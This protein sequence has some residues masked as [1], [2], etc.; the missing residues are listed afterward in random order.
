M[1]MLYALGQH[2]A[3]VSFQS[4]LQPGEKVFAFLDDVYFTCKPERVRTL[5]NSLSAFLWEH[6]FIRIN[7]GKTKI[8]NRAGILPRNCQDIIGDNGL[9]A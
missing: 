5:Y 9:S 4:H 3:L 8:W 1:P 7:L 6:A 2:A